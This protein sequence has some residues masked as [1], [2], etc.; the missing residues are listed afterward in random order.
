MGRDRHPDSSTLTGILR[1]TR[2]EFGFFRPD[3]GGED[4]YI[5]RENLGGAVHGDRVKVALFQRHP[6]DFR[7]EAAVVEILK[8][9]DRSWTGNVIRKGRAVFVA[10]D[11]VLLA[12]HLPLRTGGRR[13]AAGEKVLFH[14]EDTKRAGAMPRAVLDEIVGEGDDPRLDHLVVATQFALPESF[15]PEVEEEAGRA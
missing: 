2:H 8:R 4:I 13:V 5:A 15:S 1:G 12:D 9:A 11:E 14:L 3:E 10:P 7:M 6:R